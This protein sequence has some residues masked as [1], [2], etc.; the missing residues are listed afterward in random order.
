MCLQTRIHYVCGCLQSTCTSACLA[1]LGAA[2]RRGPHGVTITDQHL[3]ESCP[4]GCKISTFVAQ[5]GGKLEAPPETKTVVNIRPRQQSVFVGTALDA[6]GN[7][8]AE[9]DATANTEDPSPGAKYVTIKLYY[10]DEIDCEF[11]PSSTEDTSL[12]R[13]V[14]LHM[15]HCRSGN[16]SSGA[17]SGARDTYAGVKKKRAP[18]AKKT[19]PAPE[20]AIPIQD[21]IN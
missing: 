14:S 7:E 15:K 10:P 2:K 1:S 3:D 12:G 5:V 9:Q 8:M 17:P 19:K 16:K 20:S 18:R 13:E 4:W 11:E 21:P 6:A